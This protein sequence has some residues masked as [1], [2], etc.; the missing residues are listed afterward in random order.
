MLDFDFKPGEEFVIPRKRTDKRLRLS[1][2]LI[3]LL[4]I[5]VFGFAYLYLQ[6]TRQVNELQLRIEEMQ[7]EIESAAAKDSIQQFTLDPKSLHFEGVI[8]GPKGQAYIFE[9][10]MGKGYVLTDN[11]VIANWRI[12]VEGDSLFFESLETG[13]KVGVQVGG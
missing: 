7:S 1:S 11:I 12:H 2:I 8:Q 3:G 6:K 5:L 10:A 4:L 13:E 9:D